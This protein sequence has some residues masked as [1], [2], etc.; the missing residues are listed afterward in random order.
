M[1]ETCRKYHNKSKIQWLH[2]AVTAPVDSALQS[3]VSKCRKYD[4]WTFYIVG[5]S[6]KPP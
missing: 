2:Q 3:Y 1:S 6:D 5:N 4:V